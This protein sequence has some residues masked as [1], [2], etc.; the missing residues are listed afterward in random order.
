MTI[1]D[2]NVIEAREVSLTYPD[3]TA[4]LKDIE[5]RIKPGELVYITGPSGSGK[6]SL[7]KLFL[8]VEYPTSGTLKVLGQFMVKGQPKELRGLRRSIGPVF[9]EFRLIKGRTAIENVMQGMRFLDIPPGQLRKNAEE[10]L[11]KVGLEHKALSMV[12]NLSWGECQR[13]AIARAVARKPVL[14]L[15]DEPTGNLDK[16]N[17]LKILELLTSFKDENTSVIITTHATHLIE[18]E[19]AAG[20]IRMENGKLSWENIGG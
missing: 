2:D 17:A 16:D 4:A 11:F 1:G 19:K 9:Q 8:G 5:L 15:A 7:L 10:A 13:V 20:H 14:I 18:G 3:G 6:T 12:E